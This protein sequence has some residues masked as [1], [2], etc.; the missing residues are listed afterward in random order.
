MRLCGISAALQ[1]TRV[2]VSSSEMSARSSTTFT[3]IR[4]ERLFAHIGSNT[5]LLTVS[6]ASEAIETQRTMPDSLGS[7]S[8]HWTAGG[9]ETSQKTSDFTAL[10][11]MHDMHDM[12]DVSFTDKIDKAESIRFTS[13]FKTSTTAGF[14]PTELCT[15]EYITNRMK[16]I[17][18]SPGVL[19]NQALNGIRATEEVQSEIIDAN[20]SERLEPAEKIA[21]ICDVNEWLAAK[22]KDLEATEPV[23]DGPS[24]DLVAAQREIEELDGELQ[25]EK[26]RSAKLERQLDKCYLEPETT[27]QTDIA[28]LRLG[29][30]ILL[31]QVKNLSSETSSLESELRAFERVIQQLT[32]NQ[33][34]ATLA[35]N[36]SQP[37]PGL[38]GIRGFSEPTSGQ[39][40]IRGSAEPTPGLSGSRG[41]SVKSSN[42]PTYEGKWTL[43]DVTAFLFALEWH[44][45]NAAQAIGWVGTTCWGEQAVLHLKGDAAVWAMH[46]FPMSAPIEWSTFCTELNAKFIPSNALD[47][48]KREWEDLSQKNAEH[49]T[50]FNERF[51]RLLSMLD[52]HQPMPAEMLADAY[53]YM[54]KNGTQGVYKD[55]VRYIGMRDRTPTLEQ[56]MEHLATL[57]TSLNKSQSGC[58]PNTPTTMKASA[59]KMDSKRG[60]TTGTVGPAKDDGLTRYNCHQVGHISCNCPNRDLMK[61]LLEQALV[62]KDAQKANSWHPRK[63]KQRGGALAGRKQSGRLGEE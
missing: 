13:R 28:Q 46:R 8:N 62:G 14:Q 33:V 42:L 29:K 37:P 12:Q 9:S 50:E 57:D 39:F 19:S 59:R 40:G 31:Q 43:D 63:D 26:R 27:E 49:S 35:P 16:L 15:T 44:F 54:V 6:Q 1:E 52:P 30:D 22:V 24:R 3:S 7:S 5:R 48:V 61:K 17:D 47:L 55:L 11:A 18:E 58:G 45:K 53:G 10:P 32:T 34:H 56:Y 36:T 60:G 38:F 41:F 21:K 20:L 2:L 23:Q 51:R 4:T 25:I